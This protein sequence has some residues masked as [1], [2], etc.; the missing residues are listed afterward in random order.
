M[1]FKKLVMHDTDNK[2]QDMASGETAVPFTDTVTISD[3]NN[4]NGKRNGYYRRLDKEKA[5]FNS[6]IGQIRKTRD[7]RIKRENDFK[8]T[9]SR[10]RSQFKA[11]RIWTIISII[12]SALL[13]FLAMKNGATLWAKEVLIPEAGFK[14]FFALFNGSTGE[15]AG[16]E[17][18]I[19]A[20]ILVGI[21]WL[22]IFIWCI[23]E[24]EFGSCCGVFFG[25]M[26]IG[27]A[28][29][30]L[31]YLLFRLILV[32]L[33][34]VIYFILTPLGLL[35]LALTAIIIV[36]CVGKKLELKRFKVKVFINIV[37]LLVIS[38]GCAYFGNGYVQDNQTYYDDHN[39]SSMTTALEVESDNTY[40][41][42]IRETED[43]EQ[44]AYY[45]KFTPTKSGEYNFF[46]TG[47]DCTIGQLYSNTGELLTS[48]GG[49]SKSYEEFD[50]HYNLMAN[51]TYY[52]KVYFGRDYWD[53]GHFQVHIEKN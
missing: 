2:Y 49:S 42:Y 32:G 21:T 52:L 24:G 30:S 22:I 46:S 20:A 29:I 1:D 14:H 27:A 35:A 41:V 39:G 50:I 25:G 10:D 43:G 19:L 8:A 23:K 47:G 31:P 9:K 45:L 13:S 18:G 16:F 7:A 33:S 51:Q 17:I 11:C 36:Y 53:A 44:G 37:L 5:E 28:P 40:T 15:N 38:L 12:V 26:F 34:W 48:D 4:Y 3:Y 6:A